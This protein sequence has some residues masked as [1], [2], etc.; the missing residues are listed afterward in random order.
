MC[1]TF[2]TVAEADSWI[3]VLT[4]RGWHSRLWTLQPRV[5]ALDF[6]EDLLLDVRPR[7]TE[8]SR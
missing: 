7:C 4:Q 3:A 8:A 2:T 5:P 6:V 1:T